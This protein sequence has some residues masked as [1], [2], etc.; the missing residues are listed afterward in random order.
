MNKFEFEKKLA[1]IPEIEPDEIDNLMIADSA[2]QNDGTYASLNDFR[3]LM[4]YNGKISLRIPRS[5][6]MQLVED[7]KIEGISL[8]QYALYKLSR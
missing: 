5:L 2:V 7:A 1:S 8:N 4:D 3:T 6:H